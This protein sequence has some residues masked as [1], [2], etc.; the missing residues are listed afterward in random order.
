MS[1]TEQAIKGI[2]WTSGAS[3]ATVLISFAG[4][5]VLARLL[6]PEDFGTYALATSTLTII[7]VIGGFGSQEAIIQCR[8]SSIHALIPTAF[9]M[10]IG[11]G[12]VLSVAGTLLGLFF[13]NDRNELL[14]SLIV[15]LSWIRLLNMIA[16]AYQATLVRE[17]NYQPLAYQ[18][19]FPTLFA[20]IISVTMAAL[21]FG[22]WSLLASELTT[23]MAKLIMAKRASSFRLGRQFNR[24]AA[25]WIWDFGWRSMVSRMGEVA[26]GKWDNLV[27]GYFMGTAV[28]GN[29]SVA[30]R[31]A[32]VG[33][34]L[35]Q[36]PIAA[37]SHSTYAS[38]QTESDNLRLALER[39]LFWLFR[40]AMLLAL[41]VW[42]AGAE[43]TVLLYGDKWALAGDSFKNMFLFVALL[44]L[45]AHLRVFLIGSGHINRQL[46][47]Q[48]V[49]L[50][51]FSPLLL[52]AAYR[53]NLIAVSWALN[54]SSVIT[55]LAMIYFVQQVV[56]IDWGY[57]MIRPLAAGLASFL[58]ALAANQFL[59]GLALASW[60]ST[61]VMIALIGG[62]Y[63]ALMLLVNGR[64]LRGEFDLI[65]THLR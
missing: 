38:A 49:Q 34:Q 6:F 43:M 63:L 21:G 39:A 61:G 23:T 28:L 32:T 33:S 13:M 26:F 2:F 27:V 57:V 19:F 31:L 58:L 22:V 20:A 50:L 11:L 40:S 65:R 42:F 24:I 51:A 10:T 25:K 47:T 55:L 18:Q 59:D 48:V 62:I 29:Y 7:F 37:L 35:T 53:E 14:G 17:L 54:V 44:P 5:L 1:R 64:A 30:Y 52:V 4:N 9:W 15:V 12:L 8:D 56:K 36:Q 3:Y 45:L 60:L 46:L 16:L 41:L